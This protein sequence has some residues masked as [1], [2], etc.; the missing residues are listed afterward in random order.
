M[1]K[2][3]DCKR[4]II[5]EF[6]VFILYLYGVIVKNLLLKKAIFDIGY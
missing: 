3:N 1:G 6:Y 2:K 4:L 5:I